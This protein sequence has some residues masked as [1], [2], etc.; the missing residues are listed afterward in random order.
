MPKKRLTPQQLKA[1]MAARA[2]A[3]RGERGAFGRVRPESKKK[4]GD[5]KKPG[6][7]KKMDKKTAQAHAAFYLERAA[8]HSKAG[9]DM[10]KQG[11][12]GTADH[13][14]KKANEHRAHARELLGMRSFFDRKKS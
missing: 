9:R 14:F 12:K 11:M 13:H 10:L 2:G 8:H 7:L 1:I 4:T 3:S 5:D 6:G